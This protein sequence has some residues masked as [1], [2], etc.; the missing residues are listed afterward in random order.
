MQISYKYSS[1][2]IS[3]EVREEDSE[4]LHT[5]RDYVVEYVNNNKTT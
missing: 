3:V 5:F 2:Q 4:E 1:N